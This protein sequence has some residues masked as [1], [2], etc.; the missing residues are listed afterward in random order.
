[1]P[2]PPRKS[3]VPPL[4]TVGHW[5]EY[6]VHQFDAAGLVYGHGTS[7]AL[8]EA[9]F[10]IL[11]RFGLPIDGLDNFMDRAVTPAEAEALRAIIDQRI[12]S[13]KPAAYLLNEAWIGPYRFYVDERVI[14][15]RSFIGELL[16]GG[17][18]LLLEEAPPVKRV[19]DLCTGSGCLAILAAERFPDALVDAADISSD[20]LAV[21]RRNVEDYGLT[22]RI[23]LV[24]SDLMTALA[25]ERYNLILTNPPYVSA[26]EVAAFP[27]EH[28]AEPQIAHLGGDDGLDLVRSII[29][30]ARDHL[31]PH[32]LL[33]AEIG[34]GGEALEQHFPKLP[35]LWLETETSSGEVFALAASDLIGLS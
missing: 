18:E 2:K 31:T 23:R 8:D 9:A 13:R 7:N 11:R 6:T 21:A 26:E 20:A 34:L 12:T 15:P 14:V 17:I 27:P 30:Q 32:G 22:D 25:N 19:L 4:P 35:F 5:L 33:I 10:L 16:G 24:Q 29:H 1:M 3:D 28:L